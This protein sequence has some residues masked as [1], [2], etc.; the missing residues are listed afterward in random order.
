[1]PVTEF[2]RGYRSAVYFSRAQRIMRAEQPNKVVT[3]QVFQREDDTV[4]CG[5]DEAIA[6]L[7]TCSGEYRDQQEA[8]Y[9]FDMYM[10]ERRRRPVDLEYKLDLLWAPAWEEL[11]VSALHDGDTV[12]P[13]EPVMLIK[14]RYSQFAHL[15]SLYLGALARGSKVATNSRRVCEAANGKPV[16]FFADRFD[17]YATQGNDGYAAKVGGCTGFA[18]DAMGAYWGEPG[19]GTMPHALIA[20]YDG[21]VVEA[22]RAFQRQVPGVPLIA[23][24]DFN[25]DCVG[26][27]VRC[28]KAFGKDLFAVRLD[29]SGNMVDKSLTDPI[30]AGS[31]KLGVCP[32]LVHSVRKALDAHCGQHVKIVVS[33][34]F[35]PERITAFEKDGVPVDSYAVGSSLLKGSIDFTADIVEPVA[36]EGR[37]LRDTS[38]LERV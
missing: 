10:E 14:G 8:E 15:E 23:L 1:M 9:W 11:E 25:N 19:V 26:D 32:L 17:H 18:T 33:G 6:I 5:V 27:S 30:Y 24:V 3:M 29:T 34:G 28:L 31:K 22:A 7:K 35:N 38:R 36:K 4:V 2:R 13:W 20:S 16:L 21:D 37:W 12:H